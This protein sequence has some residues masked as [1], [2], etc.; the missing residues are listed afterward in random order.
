MSEPEKECVNLMI[1]AGELDYRTVIKQLD[2]ENDDEIITE[3]V[4]FHAQQCAEKYLK[5]YL[6]F[7]KKKAP[8]TH[9]LEDLKKLC[10][11]YDE[12]LAE[13]DLGKLSEYAVYIRYPHHRIPIA[14]EARE[15]HTKAKA[16]RNHII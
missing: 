1:Y 14:S 4:C 2:E 5:A 13:L 7:N 16:I 8:R 15:A 6:I 3:T 12:E 11:Q 10:I 9:V